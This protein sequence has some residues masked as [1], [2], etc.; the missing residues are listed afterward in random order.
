MHKFRV[1]ARRFIG[2]LQQKLS[3]PEPIM[4]SL[5]LNRSLSMF[6]VNQLLFIP[7]DPVLH[8][9]LSVHDHFL[10]NN[11][12]AVLSLACFGDPSSPETQAWHASVAQTV[13]SGTLPIRRRTPLLSSL[14][15]DVATQPVS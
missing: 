7:F 6:K 5:R 2:Q 14:T 9:V 1:Q 4:R 10:F 8:F 12:L 3:V 11:L 15:P 13:P